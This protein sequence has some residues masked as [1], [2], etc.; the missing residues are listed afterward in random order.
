[1]AA[2]RATN[3]EMAVKAGQ[4]AVHARELSMGEIGYLAA[5]A[6]QDDLLT[7][8]FASMV[9]GALSMGSRPSSFTITCEWKR[10][11]AAGD[12][13]GGDAKPQAV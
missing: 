5:A 10:R 11:Q 8:V 6:S 1:M 9:H 4:A 3:A 7:P 12:A 13:A 2:D